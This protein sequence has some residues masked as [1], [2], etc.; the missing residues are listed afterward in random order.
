MTK[1][2][3]FLALASREMT[4]YSTEAR[5]IEKLRQKYSILASPQQR[6]AIRSELVAKMEQN[7]LAPI[8]QQNRFAIALPFWGVG[9]LGL[10][11]GI[12]MQRPLDF[13]ATVVAFPLAVLIQKTG[14]DLETINLVIAT[15]DDI[16]SP[17]TN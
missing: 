14:F 17:S 11:L 8:L 10:L 16:D 7:Q 9:G 2:T 4:E 12:S 3:E 13:L 15:I 5:K 1:T 6:Q